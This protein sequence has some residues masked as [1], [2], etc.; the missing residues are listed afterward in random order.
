VQFFSM[1][2]QTECKRVCYMPPEELDRRPASVGIA[3]PGSE[4]FII[5]ENGERLPPGEVGELVVNGPHVMKGYWR[6]PELTAQRFRDAEN[7][8]D[9]LLFTGDLFRMDEEGYLYFVARQDDIIKSRGEKVSPREVENVV[10]ELDGVAE[11]AVVGAPDPVLGQA[12]RLLVVPHE[13]IQ[14]SEREVRA[15]CARKLDDFMIPKYVEIVAELPRNDNGK[16]DKLRIAASW[17]EEGPAPLAIPAARPPALSEENQAN[18]AAEY[19]TAFVG[20]E[21]GEV[22]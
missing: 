17:Q 5:G 1:Y 8:E 19:A 16:V 22:A 7:P 20:K 3:I 11:A 4:V 18:G 15:H 2:G 13:G 12:V 9:R 14:L 10:C 6:A 21:R